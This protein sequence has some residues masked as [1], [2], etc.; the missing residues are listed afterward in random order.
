MT[1]DLHTRVDRAAPEELSGIVFL[2]AL[3]GVLTTLVLL[4]V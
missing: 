2:L 3:L 1:A 4:F